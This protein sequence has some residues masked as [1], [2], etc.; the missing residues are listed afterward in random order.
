MTSTP[1]SYYSQPKPLSSLISGDRVLKNQSYCPYF[2][3]EL[4]QTFLSVPLQRL[5]H[6]CTARSALDPLWFTTAREDTS[7][8]PYSIEKIG[9]LVPTKTLS[10]LIRGKA[11]SRKSGRSSRGLP[12]PATVASPKEK[13]QINQHQYHFNFIFYDKT[14][15]SWMFS[16][17]YYKCFLRLYI[18]LQF[19]INISIISC[20]PKHPLVYIHAWE[21]T[22]QHYIFACLS[23]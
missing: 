14:D 4:N 19:C 23:P 7:T 15:T 11:I 3:I 5:H 12:I 21:C 22:P 16:F 10:V 18:K 20:H 8:R 9:L 1:I 13:C 2:F 6:V 17:S